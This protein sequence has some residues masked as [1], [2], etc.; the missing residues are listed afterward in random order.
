MRSKYMYFHTLVLH[1]K[2]PE[3]EGKIS[4]RYGVQVG[5]LT[6]PGQVAN[7]ELVFA[8]SVSHWPREYSALL[9]GHWPAPLRLRGGL[10]GWCRPSVALCRGRRRAWRG[11]TLPV[12]SSAREDSVVQVAIGKVI[13]HN[14]GR[15]STIRQAGSYFRHSTPSQ[16][17]TTLLKEWTT[18]G[19]VNV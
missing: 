12:S 17:H 19:S 16:T 15:S 2:T 5:R 11:L 10:A 4:H 9:R 8:S 6:H 13:L 18:W 3:T 14:N 7:I 1:A